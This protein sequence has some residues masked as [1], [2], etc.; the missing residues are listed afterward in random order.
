[1]LCILLAKSL[2]PIIPL[3]KK[4]VD[5]VQ[6]RCWVDIGFMV[7]SQ[8]LTIAYRIP[9]EYLGQKRARKAMERT[10]AVLQ[11]TVDTR[12]LRGCAIPVSNRFIVVSLDC[13]IFIKCV[14]TSV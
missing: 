10:I 8:I 9:R 6:C 4:P 7:V 3:W 5:I 1:M 14:L 13:S 11:T 12:T 2:I